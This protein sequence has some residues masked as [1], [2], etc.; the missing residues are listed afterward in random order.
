MIKSEKMMAIMDSSHV[1]WVKTHEKIIHCVTQHMKLA[2]VLYMLK[3]NGLELVHKLCLARH[4]TVSDVISDF[5]LN[6]P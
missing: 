6:K 1:T 3:L 2:T 4:K 5:W